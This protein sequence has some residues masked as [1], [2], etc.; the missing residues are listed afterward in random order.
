MLLKS[1]PLSYYRALHA[2]LVLANSHGPSRW[3]ALIQGYVNNKSYRNALLVFAEKQSLN[4]RVSHHAIIP[5]VLKACAALSFAFSGK[6]IHGDLLKSGTGC[7]LYIQTALVDMYSK[8]KFLVDARRIFDEMSQRSVVSWNA[9]IGG[10]AKNGDMGSALELF[11]LM[12]ERSS[13]SWTEM[14]DGYARIGETAMARKLFDQMPEKKSVITWTAMVNGYARNGEMEAAREIFEEMP[15]RNFFAWSSMVFGYCKCG[16]VIEAKLLFGRMEERNLV[17]WNTL[18]AGLTQNGWCEQALDVF[19]EMRASGVK[20]DG[21]SVASALSACAQLGSLEMGK[22]IH[23]LVEQIG[24]RLNQFVSNALIDMYAKCGDIT[25]ARQ[26]FNEAPEKNEVCWNSMISGVAIHGHVEEV[27][28]LFGQMRLQEVE[29]NRL[30]Y[31]A[32]LSA[33]AHA[34]YVQ[35]GMELFASMHKNHKITAGIEHYGC[36]VDLLGRAG[37]LE[38]AYEFINSMPMKPNSVIWGAMLGACRVHM[39]MGLAQKVVEKVTTEQC[40][41][42]ARYVLLSNLYAAS[43]QWEDAEKMRIMM[44]KNQIEKVPGH[45]SIMA[46]SNVEYQFLSGAHSESQTRQLYVGR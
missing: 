35:E 21:V 29:P 37:L 24:V 41:D 19:Q 11:E 15:E 26:L 38:E 6:T 17:N 43:A 20:P 14:I 30:T 5:L 42:D 31:L 40:G 16:N 32:V 27:L 39:N 3:A 34:G 13:V 2:S 1:A 44:A 25:K 46:S 22:E 18:L 12:P 36:M 45:S 7:N 8:C 9:M 23:L 4:L 10:Y 28:E 33:C